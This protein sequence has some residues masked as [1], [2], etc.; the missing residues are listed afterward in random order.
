MK[1]PEEAF[2]AAL[3]ATSSWPVSFRNHAPGVRASLEAATPII[4]NALLDGLAEVI[5]A[6][7]DS[8]QNDEK[9]TLETGYR[10][11][12]YD[13]LAAIELARKW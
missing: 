8:V 11:G 2:S 1:I 5:A 4:V 3:D 7:R 12:L 13:A 10:A 9:L 6:Q